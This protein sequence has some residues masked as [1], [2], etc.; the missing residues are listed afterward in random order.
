MREESFEA[1]ADELDDLLEAE[2]S[3]LLS[4]DLDQIGRLLNK[5]ENLV[6]RF[7]SSDTVDKENLA[8]VAGKLKRNQDLLDQALGGIRSVAKRLAALKRV[9]QSLDTY[10]SRGEKKSVDLAT[11]ATVEKRS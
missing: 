7:S 1:I 3:A 4:G 8:L 11:R 5:K 10:N 6:E 9:R 2:R